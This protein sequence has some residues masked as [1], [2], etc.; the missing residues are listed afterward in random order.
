MSFQY[1]QIQQVLTGERSL[2]DA[3]EAHGTLA[4]SL[5]AATTGYAFEDWLAEILPEGAAQPP[6]RAELQ[7]V[8]T[9]TAGSLEGADMAFE[10]LLPADEE[11]IEARASALGLWCQGFLYGL[12]SSGAQDASS[13]SGQVGEIVRDLTEI[14]HVGV[15]GEESEDSNESAYAELVEF[16]RAG[17]Q[18]VFIELHERHGSRREP[19]PGPSLH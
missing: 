14:T 4:G 18:L 7:A 15:D 19:T 16:V 3:A 8:Y 9:Q 5:C 13:W 2:A 17:V 12:G 1:T 6:A 11:P 10:L